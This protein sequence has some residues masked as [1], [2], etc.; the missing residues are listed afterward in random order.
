MVLT[1]RRGKYEDYGQEICSKEILSEIRL[2]LLA[3]EYGYR[4][5]L[6]IF[7]KHGL[8]RVEFV[9]TLA[10]ARAVG[11]PVR[12]AKGTVKFFKLSH[13]GNVRHYQW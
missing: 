6:D 2:N 10:E 4:Y 1:V 9:R 12:R 13:D 3:L 5:R 7:P 11:R 8:Y